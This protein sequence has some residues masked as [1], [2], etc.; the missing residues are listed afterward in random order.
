MV[1]PRLLSVAVP[2]LHEGPERQPAGTARS[3]HGDAP[4]LRRLSVGP[5]AAAEVRCAAG[6]TAA[7]SANG[8]GLIGRHPVEYH[9]STF[10]NS[11]PIRRRVAPASTPA[12]RRS[13]GRRKCPSDAPGASRRFLN[14]SVASEASAALQR[15]STGFYGRF[16]LQPHCT[17]PP[18]RRRWPGPAPGGPAVEAPFLE[19]I[20]QRGEHEVDQQ[21]GMWPQKLKSTF[22]IT[23][24][25]NR[26]AGTDISPDRS[27]PG[28]GRQGRQEARGAS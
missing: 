24:P 21:A 12:G 9:K 16:S 7:G 6:R 25:V 22:G 3:A 10:E 20:G 1:R 17:L 11:V 4:H 19:R 15:A 27:I 2:G 8:C 26:G 18:P 28:N 14:G 13:A 23:L 5:G